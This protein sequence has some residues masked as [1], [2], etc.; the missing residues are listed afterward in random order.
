M[1]A[2]EREVVKETP[3]PKETLRALCRDHRKD[4]SGRFKGIKGEIP[5]RKDHGDILLAQGTLE[6]V[7]L[8]GAT[9]ALRGHCSR[10][11]REPGYYSRWWQIL[12]NRP[13][14]SG[15]AGVQGARVRRSWGHPPEFQRK[16]WEASKGEGG[17]PSRRP[18][19]W[20]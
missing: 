1:K 9:Q 14:G 19:R 18:S 12:D 2:K 7:P 15:S 8:C 5:L 10:G 13:R 11:P 4:G 20:G 17:S 3:S 6:D 16:A